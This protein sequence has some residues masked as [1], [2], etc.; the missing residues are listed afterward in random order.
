MIEITSS[1]S[2]SSA[3]ST[4]NPSATNPS[5]TQQS[6]TIQQPTQSLLPKY[7]FFKYKENDCNNN[8]NNNDSNN[9]SN[10]DSNSIKWSK[11]LSV[12][13]TNIHDK[14][15]VY[16][17]TPIANVIYDKYPKSLIHLLLLPFNVSFTDGIRLYFANR[18]A[19]F[20]YGH[21]RILKQIHRVCR[22][23]CVSLGNTYGL[24]IIAGYHYVPSMEDLHIHIISTDF[25]YAKSR[26]QKKSFSN[27]NF[28]TIDQVEFELENYG[29]IL[30]YT[31]GERTHRIFDKDPKKDQKD[32]KDPRNRKRDC[33]EDCSEGYFENGCYK[34]VP[35]G[36]K[37]LRLESQENR[38][39]KPWI[40]S[41]R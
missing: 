30:K 1:E 24:N 12:Y 29:H 7:D 15:W 41:R 9:C 13:K 2:S 40:K 18:P 39:F 22:V 35:G 5:A 25:S 38:N 34:T 27:K 31:P 11:S 14:K 19:Q 8:G 28:I 21:L 20:K 4:T 26:N 17:Y 10:K 33:V 37:Q 36:N 3:P 23:L 32:Q 6:S 16:L